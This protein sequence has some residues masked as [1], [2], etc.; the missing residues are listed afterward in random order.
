[1]RLRR[2]VP[3]S[4]ILFVLGAL[5]ASTGESEASTRLHGACTPGSVA[6]VIAGKRSCLKVGQV[7]KRS[8]DKRYHV[9]K[10]HCHTGR[11]TRLTAPPAP[12]PPAPSPLPGQRVDVGGYRLYIECT[13]SGSPTIVFEAGQGGAAATAPLPGAVGI[14]QTI[15]GEARVC[16]YDR[17]GLGASDARPANV[18][19]TGAQY[20][21]ELHALL[22][23]AN[24]P[25]PYVL[26]GPS[27]GGLVIASYASRFPA[28]TAG[29]VF[30]DSDTCSQTCTY[31][32]PE[33]GTF[34]LTSA[35]FGNR[36]TA[37]LLAEFGLQSDGRNLV[38]RSTNHILATALG[39]GHAIIQDKPQVVTAAIHLVATA[40]R[41]GAALPDCPVSGLPAVGG[42]C[43]AT[44]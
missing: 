38:G 21:Q 41:T 7:C 19:P 4:P 44:G 42:R 35:T 6:A 14:R 24:V 17:A 39:S 13:G 1:M 2:L 40:A 30:V 20:A 10:F 8:A 22:T 5:A 16:A 29:L 26:V 3:G 37:V 15:A 28:E 31:D 27:Y 33:A 36:P 34:D 43:E 9:Y 11:L 32:I 23:G 18:A 25:G 12:R